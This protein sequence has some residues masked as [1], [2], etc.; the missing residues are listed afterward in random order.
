MSASTSRSGGWN[1]PTFAMVKMNWA[2]TTAEATG[3]PGWARRL[4]GPYA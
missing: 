3:G 4:L 1:R 2:A